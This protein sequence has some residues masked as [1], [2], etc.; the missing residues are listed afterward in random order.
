MARASS[1]RTSCARVRHDGEELTVSVGLPRGAA[2]KI[3]EFPGHVFALERTRTVYA[4]EEQTLMSV[5][6]PSLMLPVTQ[7]NQEVKRDRE[8]RKDEKI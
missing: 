2:C 8:G 5:G 4:K 7:G 1:T 6:R 3:R